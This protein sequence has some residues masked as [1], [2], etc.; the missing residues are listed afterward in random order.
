MLKVINIV[1][2]FNKILKEK[3]KKFLKYEFKKKNDKKKYVTNL[4]ENLNVK[5]IYSREK[6]EK[7]LI[8]YFRENLKK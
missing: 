2:I 3:K 6:S 7:V 1:E 4:K 8:E 5:T